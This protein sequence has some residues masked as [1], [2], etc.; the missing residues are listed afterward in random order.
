MTKPNGTY[1][2]GVVVLDAPTDWAEGLRVAVLVPNQAVGCQEDDSPLTADEIAAALKAFDD[3]PAPTNEEA[4][5]LDRAI[6]EA[7]ATSGPNRPVADRRAETRNGAA[8][9]TPTVHGA[10]SQSDPRP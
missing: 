2:N 3:V 8:A 6:A 7:R 5:D 9:G 10:P 1:R 4:A